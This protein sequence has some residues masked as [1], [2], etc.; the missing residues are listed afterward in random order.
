[1]DHDGPISQRSPAGRGSPRR[2]RRANPPPAAQDR[3]VERPLTP[4][5]RKTR[6]LRQAA[7][8][9]PQK[10]REGR[11]LLGS[12]F[13]A[14]AAGERIAPPTHCPAPLQEANR[15]EGSY[16]RYELRGKGSRS[17]PSTPVIYTPFAL[18]YTPNAFRRRQ[19]T[20]KPSRRAKN[21]PE[22][23]SQIT[24]R[25]KGAPRKAKPCGPDRRPPEIP[26]PSGGPKDSKAS[27]AG[28]S[29]QEHQGRSRRSHHQHDKK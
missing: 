22:Q 26:R 29:F 4:H 27:P 11:P 10:I 18:L 23:A 16:G 1:M 12:P 8:T 2:N 21:R 14:N 24:E 5:H 20:K 17:F 28:T 25:R 7:P 15:V 13:F 3:S 9:C 19:I 6:T